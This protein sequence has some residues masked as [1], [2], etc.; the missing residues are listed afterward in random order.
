MKTN[1]HRRNFFNAVLAGVLA[2]G[3]FAGSASAK[4]VTSYD[5]T[6]LGTIPEF[7]PELGLGWLEGYL[8]PDALPEQPR[9]DPP[10]SG[11]RL[12]RLRAGRG[13]RPRHLRSR[14]A[15]RASRWPNPTTT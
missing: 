6:A 2:A 8:G 7:H 13:G 11:P 15:R 10:A 12:G 9:P 4:D 5:G 3:L 14:A 1:L